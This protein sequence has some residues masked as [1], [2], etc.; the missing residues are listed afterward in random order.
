MCFIVVVLFFTF[1]AQINWFVC[2]CVWL[3]AECR[4]SIIFWLNYFMCFQLNFGYYCANNQWAFNKFHFDSWAKF[5]FSFSATIFSFVSVNETFFF[6]FIE[7]KTNRLKRKN[8][9]FTE[10]KL[11]YLLNES[12]SAVAD[13]VTTA[14]FGDTGKTLDGNCK[15]PDKSIMQNQ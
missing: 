5:E 14:A 6:S 15:K 12:V 3:E 10:L 8:P 9:N 13:G 11:H 7:T 4:F 1:N 2:V